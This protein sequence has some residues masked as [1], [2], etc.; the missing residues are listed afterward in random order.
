VIQGENPKFAGTQMKIGIGKKR[1]MG[2]KVA[3]RWG[4]LKPRIRGKENRE[5]SR[6]ALAMK[7]TKGEVGQSDARR[8]KTCKSRLQKV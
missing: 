6:G 4:N 3:R 2:K 8:K 7:I 1:I 5:G